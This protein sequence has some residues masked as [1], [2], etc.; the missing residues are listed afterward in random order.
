EEREA[1][2]VAE[3]EG[4]FF[5]RLPDALERARK[6][7]AAISRQLDGVD[8]RSIRDRTALAGIP[9]VRK[10][11]LVELQTAA[12]SSNAASN[13][14]QD[15]VFGGFSTIGWGDAARV[16]CSPGPIYEPES[17]RSDYWG[18]ARALYAA[19][20]RRGALV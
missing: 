11:E 4:Q 17:H 6:S 2:G 9:V 13:A 7:A 5:S 20:F 15:R 10:S 3:R 8:V 18:F 1:M 19:G 12:H 14:V 16:F